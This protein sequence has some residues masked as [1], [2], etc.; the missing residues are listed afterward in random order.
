VLG[1]FPSGDYQ[2]GDP[3]HLH[4]IELF[5]SQT[6]AAV[7]GAEIAAT[8]VK[9]ESEV[10]KERL[11]NL[12]L[13]TFSADIREPLSEISQIVSELF[14]PEAVN[15][16]AKRALLLEKIRVKTKDL[17]EL[18]AELPKIITGE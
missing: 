15:D 5:A 9:I 7:E 18:A 4:M 6:A 12:I 8:A 11:Q 17:N 14:E 1:V 3:D 16:P 2:F 10:E 13:K